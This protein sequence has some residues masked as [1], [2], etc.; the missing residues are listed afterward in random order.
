MT[1]AG[2]ALATRAAPGLSGAQQVASLLAYEFLRDGKF[3]AASGPVEMPSLLDSLGASAAA[4][5]S[6]DIHRAFGD[7]SVQSVGYEEGLERPKVH[8]Y[9][10]RRPPKPIKSLPA[11]IDG[12]PVKVHRMGPIAVRADA[13]AGTNTPGHLFLRGDRICCGSSC[14]PTSEDYAGTLGALVT[15]AALDGTYL[16]SNNHIF[17][18]CNHVPRE[19]P[20]VAPSPADMAHSVRAPTEIG[21][22]EYIHELRSGDPNLVE[23]CETDLALARATDGRIITSWQGADPGYDTPDEV[24]PPVTDMAVKKF[25]RTTALTEGV[26]EARVTAPMAVTY[27]AKHFRGTVWFN[28]I[29]TVRGSVKAPFARQGD[30]GSL[31]V[32]KDGTKAVGLL[33]AVNGTGE[34]G[35]VIPMPRVVQAFGGLQLVTGHGV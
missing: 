25:G 16:L 14:A 13:A 28:D 9:L 11:A 35:W 22:N 26:V 29:W 1:H 17:A 5:E 32:T 2:T 27:N 6:R 33:F 12:I 21:R 8:I 23:P 19:Q 34:Y 30:S 18:G 15:A 24:A 20:I 3:S 4:A 31:V 10:T 7:V